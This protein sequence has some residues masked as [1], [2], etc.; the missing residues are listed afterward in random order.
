MLLRC[1]CCGK[2]YPRGFNWYV[3]NNCGFRICPFCL[4]KHQGRY[5]NGGFKCS[6]CFP[7]QM[8][9]VHGIGK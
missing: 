6:Q 3:C 4:S 2:E 5:S 8:K 7:G 1:Q 9:L